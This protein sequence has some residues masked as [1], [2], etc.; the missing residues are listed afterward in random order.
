PV[1]QS[2]YNEIEAQVVVDL[3][4]SLTT[5]ENIPLLTIGIITSYR[6]QL[7]L[8]QQQLS[9]NI[10]V[11][12]V[13][14]FQGRE[15]DIILLSSVRAQQQEEDNRRSIGFVGNKQRLNVSLTRGKYAVYIIGH[16]QSLNINEHWSKLINDATRRNCMFEYRSRKQNFGWLRKEQ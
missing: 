15:K 8:I 9:T 10:D 3:I 14:G 11:S 16:L 7:Q 2:Y 1:I 13:D 5:I 4:R 12:T 6:K